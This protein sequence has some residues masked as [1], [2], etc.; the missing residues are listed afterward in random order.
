MRAAECSAE[1]LACLSRVPS[2]TK[3]LAAD[4]IDRRETI[5]RSFLAT[6]NNQ[7]QPRLLWPPT[8]MKRIAFGM[9]AGVLALAPAGLSVGFQEVTI[10]NGAKPSLLAGVWYPTDA[11]AAESRLGNFRQTVSRGAPVRGERLALVVMSHG[12]GGWYGGHYDTALALARA[13]FVVAAV[14][15]DGDTFDDQSR[16]LELWR[17]PAQIKRLV[18]YMLRGWEQHAHVDAGRVGAFGFSNGAF[19]V[20]VAVGGVPDLGRIGPYCRAHPSHDLC[21]AFDH[22]GIDPDIE[23][24]VPA[25]AWIAD[26]R[27]RAAV[28]AAPAFGFTFDHQGL[29]TVRVPIQLWRAALDTHQPSPYYDEV[30]RANL[31]RPPEYHVVANGGHY[32]FLPPCDEDLSRTAPHLCTSV[33]GFD[34]AAFHERFNR[35]I[36]R[37]F[38]TT[39]R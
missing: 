16:V 31:P 25:N 6:S 29:S 13:G 32:D 30:V 1:S 7:W 34:R 37:F 18:D 24:R 23:S 5:A 17:R 27:I 12:G 10:S 4:T 38:E 39:L 9:L 19:T 28:I 36:V 11:A 14:N 15:H 22:A 33:P 21:Q 20:L 3:L 35:E 8:P 2:K 26:R